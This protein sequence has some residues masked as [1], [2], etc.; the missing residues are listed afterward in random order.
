MAEET[1]FPSNVQTAPGALQTTNRPSL[2]DIVQQVDEEED[3]NRI[4]RREEDENQKP[5]RTE[6]Q[7]E[8]RVVITR[9]AREANR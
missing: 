7:E 4:G 3:N 2:R 9:E 6:D 5:N 8:D 1:N